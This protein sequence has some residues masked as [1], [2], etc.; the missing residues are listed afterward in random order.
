MDLYQYIV[1]DDWGDDEEKTQL[2]RDCL[3]IL[4]KDAA[5]VYIQDPAN[6]VAMKKGLTGYEFYPIS[7]QDVAILHFVQ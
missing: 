2:Y 6:L 5:A 7:A 3:M 1:S 4:S